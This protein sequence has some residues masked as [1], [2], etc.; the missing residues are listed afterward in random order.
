VVLVRQLLQH[1][2][3]LLAVLAARRPEVE[4]HRRGH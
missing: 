3:Q 4:Q 1:R 2:R